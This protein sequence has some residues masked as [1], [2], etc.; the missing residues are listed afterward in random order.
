MERFLFYRNGSGESINT[1]E[2]VKYPGWFISTSQN[3]MKQVDMCKDIKMDCKR[4]HE[5]ILNDQKE[6]Q[7]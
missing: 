7:V 2:S 4:I 1:F 3:D 6:N 5:F